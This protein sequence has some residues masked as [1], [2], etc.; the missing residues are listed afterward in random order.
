MRASAFLITCALKP[1]QRPRSPAITTRPTF[2]TSR[3]ARRGMSGASVLACSSRPPRTR[4]RAVEKGRDWSTASCARRT[5]AA[6]TSFMAEVIFLVFLTEP[7]RLRSSLT[8]AISTP[9]RAPALG[10]LA[11]GAGQ[12]EPG[13]PGASAAAPGS[14]TSEPRN[15][16][17]PCSAGPRP[18]TTSQSAM[19]SEP[20]PR[21][22]EGVQVAVCAPRWSFMQPTLM[23]T[24]LV[25]AAP[26]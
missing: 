7:T 4:S 11:A 1:P 6:A 24:T 15:F 14:L 20:G 12:R 18:T 5:L 19:M 2:L 9:V 3:A 8:E 22:P 26:R 16:R 25:L 17:A 13:V 10:A 21:I 23:R